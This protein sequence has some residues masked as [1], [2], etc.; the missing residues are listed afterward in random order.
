MHMSELS[1]ALRQQITKSA[2]QIRAAH[3][4]ELDDPLS[5]DHAARLFRSIISP[6]QTAAGASVDA[7][8]GQVGSLVSEAIRAGTGLLEG[9]LTLL[10]QAWMGATTAGPRT[11]HRIEP[12]PANAEDEMLRA[13]FRQFAPMLVSALERGGDGYGL[14]ETVITLFGRVT[15]DQ[16][17]ALG[18]DKIMQLAR[19]EPD[20]WAQV[21]PVEARFSRFIDEFT[22]YDAQIA[23]EA[24]SE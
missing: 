5:A 20:I 23:R 16:A 8:A 7:L 1:P 2:R 15:Y 6:R 9:S 3:K 24:Q 14:A 17:A 4:A 21:A 11:E 22:R 12:Q 18:K 10:S 19:S 13:V